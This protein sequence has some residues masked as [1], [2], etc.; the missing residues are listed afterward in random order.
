MTLPCDNEPGHV[1]IPLPG[2]LI[3][4]CDV[5][6]LDILVSRDN[7]GEVIIYDSVAKSL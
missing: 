4:L 6:E 7:R 5:P 3:M 2:S 1:G